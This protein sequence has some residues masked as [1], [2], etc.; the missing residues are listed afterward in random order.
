MMNEYVELLFKDFHSLLGEWSALAKPIAI[1]L[2]LLF[3]VN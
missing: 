1:I 2:I 3:S